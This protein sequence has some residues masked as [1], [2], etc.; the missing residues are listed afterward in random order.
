MSHDF[1]SLSAST[2]VPHDAGTLDVLVEVSGRWYQ[3]SDPDELLQQI[4]NDLF[5][6]FTQA[7]H[8]F[9]VFKQDSKLVAKA[10]KTRWQGE[11]QTRFSR[12]IANLCID[13]RGGTLSEHNIAESKIRSM[14][15]APLVSQS[16]GLAFGVIQLDTLDV[17]KRFTVADLRLL[18]TAA[19]QGALALDVVQRRLKQSSENDTVS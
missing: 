12:K 15:S 4:L 2:V 17:T 19:A 11:E 5:R 13:K 3:F 1:G 7:N 18:M 10:S 14:I 8:G 6:L 9:I 16:N